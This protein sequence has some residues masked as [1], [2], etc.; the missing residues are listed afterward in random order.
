MRRR[1]YVESMRTSVRPGSDSETIEQWSTA[2]LVEAE[3]CDGGGMPRHGAAAPPA[4]ALGAAL[5]PRRSF[6][7]ASW[8]TADSNHQNKL[9][10]AVDPRGLVIASDKIC[11]W[12]HSH[13]DCD[14]CEQIIFYMFIWS[15]LKFQFVILHVVMRFLLW[16]SR[17][18]PMH[19]LN[20]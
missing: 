14:V 18:S 2:I 11:A 3:R 19:A 1:K 10:I 13:P 16:Y 7:S 8:Q 4:S 6:R 20:N 15:A 5:T 9:N 12:Q 17:T